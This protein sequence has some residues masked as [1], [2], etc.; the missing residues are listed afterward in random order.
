MI[1]AQAHPRASLD[2]VEATPARLLLVE[3]QR[4]MDYYHREYP[5]APSVNSIVV[6]CG[7]QELSPFISWLSD[8]L[9]IA[10]VP[11]SLTAVAQI[12]DAGLHA[13]LDGSDGFRYLRAAGL[14]MRGLDQLPSEIPAFDLMRHDPDEAKKPRARNYLSMALVA[15]IVLMLLST[16][17]VVHKVHVTQEAQ[18]ALQIARSESATLS[19]YRGMPL[20]ELKVQHMIRDAIHPPVYTVTR[21]ADAVAMCIPQDSAVADFSVDNQGLVIIQGNAGAE[22]AIVQLLDTLRQQPE[23]TRVSLD[24]LDRTTSLTDS[25][26]LAYQVSMKTR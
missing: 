26:T 1:A 20:K 24:H 16:L 2:A 7:S 10:T 25:G 5:E 3:L 17:N 15:S 9:H 6:A 12:E 21:L 19:S 8:A 11:A 23:F 18:A 14:A 4:S 22:T 13:T